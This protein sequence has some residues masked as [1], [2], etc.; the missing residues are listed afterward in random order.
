VRERADVD[1]VRRLPA[2]MELVYPGP[3]Q[4]RDE[5]LAALR[6][7]PSVRWAEPNRRVHGM[8]N[9][10]G[11]GV[12][13]AL[14]NTGQVIAGV[15][16][17]PDADIDAPAAWSQ[18]TGAGMVVG[19]VD[20]GAQL[21]HPDLQIA[22]NPGEVGAGKQTNGADDDADGYV[23]NW[24]GW[25][26]TSSDND[27]TDGY[28][29]GTHVS[30]I[31]AAGADNGVGVAGVAPAAKAL[32]L[33]VLD[34][35]GSGWISDVALAFAYAGRHGV[36]V[37]NAS[38]SSDGG[39]QVL[40]DAVSAS[41]GTLF[42]V[43][44]AND[45][46]DLDAA[47]T[48]KYPCSL[49]SAN[50]LC[51]GATD[52]TDRRAGYSNWGA[53]VVDVFAPGSSVY[54]TYLGGSYAYLSGTSMATPQVAGI[55]A[56][57]AAR[58]PE[59]STG[60]IKRRILDTVEPK[61]ALAGLCVTGGRVNAA[62]AVAATPVPDLPPGAVTGLLGTGGIEQI[63]LRWN[64]SPETDLSGYRVYR[65]DAGTFRLVS[66]PGEPRLTVAA[67]AGVPQTF[68]VTAVDRAGHESA[69]AQ[70][71]A[72]ALAVPDPP[73]EAVTG[74]AGV[75]GIEQIALGWN[76]SP[77]RDLAGYRVYRKVSGVFNLI[78]APTQARFSVVVPAGVP[79]TFRI[80]AVDR[81]AQE[82]APVEL[83]ATALT[84]PGPQ[85]RPQPIPTPSSQPT[86]APAGSIALTPADPGLGSTTPVG[87]ST[88]GARI[89]AARFSGKVMLC[90]ARR[91]R[92]GHGTLSFTASGG[93]DV[94]ISLS[95]RVCHSRRCHWHAAGTRTVSVEA[96]VVRLTA[97]RSLV[98]IKLHA[99]H[100]RARLT[101]AG[102]S[103]VVTFSV[104]RRG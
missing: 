34:A 5:A 4:S 85:P 45:G 19:V 90:Q 94:R 43:A 75:A 38:L 103:S 14:E 37:V 95:R 12:Q 65:S 10:P 81:A 27:P 101:A 46:L 51:V 24:R 22:T 102:R 33:R 83:T 1:F 21:D 13:W 92:L 16:G 2:E 96:G 82:S 71:T 25:D 56:L 64:V 99:G 42:V 58:N 49:P 3:G 67:P 39:A 98:G 73:P 9:D 36:R 20:T 78:G 31:V 88:V 89:T 74:L 79:Q 40:A 104:T 62:A 100:W 29:H 70:V 52:N 77:E 59:L 57:V 7:D 66:S 60:E 41:P 35:N 53:T 30:G 23:D 8:S 76:P 15:A 69:T 18:S 32:E 54:A 17:I 86:P 68:R 11:F 80:T 91:C 48:A 6:S 97:G 87:G 47:G 93:A 61:P 26:W 44:A 72:T 63:A 28:G 50:V 84:P 55:A